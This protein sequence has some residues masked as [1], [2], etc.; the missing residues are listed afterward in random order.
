[1]PQRASFF[2]IFFTNLGRGRNILMLKYLAMAEMLREL[3]ILKIVNKIFELTIIIG[4][5]SLYN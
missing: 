1:M 4:I 3:G 2:H 5:K